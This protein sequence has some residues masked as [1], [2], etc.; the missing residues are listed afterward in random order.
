ME[1]KMR[2]YLIVFALCGFMQQSLAEETS[3]CDR[4]RSQPDPSRK[5]ACYLLVH[6]QDAIGGWID[7]NDPSIND[8]KPIG[9]MTRQQCIAKMNKYMNGVC[10][11]RGA[12][13]AIGHFTLEYTDATT[14]ERCRVEKSKDSVIPCKR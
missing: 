13:R 7:P 1:L 2:N 6:G 8:Y 5:S 10:K 14:S 4:L 9:T 12:V 3:S 11:K